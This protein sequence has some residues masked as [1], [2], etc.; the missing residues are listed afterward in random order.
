M[1]EVEEEFFELGESVFAELCLPVSLDVSDG[2]ADRVGGALAAV[3]EG[4]ALGSA[5]GGVRFS[6]QV[7][8]GFELA[9]QFATA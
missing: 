9:D 3:G 8:E 7:S 5:V 4:D 2:V 1:V 6:L